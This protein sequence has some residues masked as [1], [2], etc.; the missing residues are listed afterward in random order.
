M[1]MLSSHINLA[2]HFILIFILIALFLNFTVVFFW[3]KK[4]YLKLGFHRKYQAIQRIHL[5]EIPRLGGLIFII[6]LTFFS[7][8]S[9]PSESIL[10]FR[11]ILLCLIPVFLI[12][13]KEDIF[14][15]VKPLTRFIAILFSSWIFTSLNIGPFP[16]LIEIPLVGK[17]FI[18]KW[19]ADFFYIL[20]M[21]AI[22]NGMNL[23]DG[24]NG[25]CAAV[26]LSI[27]GALLF[28]SYQIGDLLI[29]YS[30]LNI[31]FLLVPFLLFNYPYGRIF[32]GDMGA[33]AL[34]LII[35]FLVIIFFG[36]HPEI[37]PW[38]AVLILIY[39]ITEI[40]WT[41]LR[42][43]IR[44]DSFYK[45]DRGH[46]HLKLFYFFR[47]KKFSKQVANAIVMP[48][49]SPFWLFPLISV[50]FTFQKL[51]F[52]RVSI[53]LFVVFYGLF[54]VFLPAPK[55]SINLRLQSE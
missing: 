10:F 39:P 22:A 55:N 17:L 44:G 5:N 49:L 48:L 29:F 15:N 6:T 43:F 35:S 28:L 42:R 21:A 46:L 40:T 14:H 30:A 41:I 37:S 7:I 13:F 3:Q 25:L 32:L 19:G 4:L 12:G 16:N 26:T 27:L 33:Y 50:C 18:I 31:A 23:I 1:L 52:I 38:A 20:S 8:Y 9:K 2:N 51:P 54:Y 45:P 24:V 34:G 11:S 47:S 53:T 36:R